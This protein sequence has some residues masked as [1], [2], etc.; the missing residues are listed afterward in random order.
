[1]AFNPNPVLVHLKVSY[2]ASSSKKTCCFQENVVEE[3]ANQNCEFEVEDEGGGEGWHE[4]VKKPIFFKPSFNK[5]KYISLKFTDVA[6]T[7]QFIQD[8]NQ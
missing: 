7:S 3:D 2:E 1:M 5:L 6:L 8:S 4:E